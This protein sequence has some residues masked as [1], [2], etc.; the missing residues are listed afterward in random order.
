MAIGIDPS[1]RRSTELLPCKGSLHSSA[2][3]RVNRFFVP[4][5][6]ACDTSVYPVSI[7]ACR[8]TRR[9]P[10]AVASHALA[11]HASLL[12]CPLQ[13][14]TEKPKD[15]LPGQVVQIYEWGWEKLIEEM[16][17]KLYCQLPI[18][19]TAIS[20]EWEGRSF[21]MDV[22]KAA[23]NAYLAERRVELAE[24]SWCI[25]EDGVHIQIVGGKKPFKCTGPI[26]DPLSLAFQLPAALRLFHESGLVWAEALVLFK[27]MSEDDKTDVR[28]MLSHAIHCYPALFECDCAPVL[29]DTFERLLRDD[30]LDVAEGVHKHYMSF[31]QN[32]AQID[33]Y[34][35]RLLASMFLDQGLWERRLHFALFQSD[36]LIDYMECGTSVWGRGTPGACARRVLGRWAGVCVDVWG[37]GLW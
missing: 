13:E 27:C 15:L 26:V 20:P 16:H 29:C 18:V 21:W 25:S 24:G 37:G 17:I 30:D 5:L 31:V 4:F 2:R 6:F 23:Y 22:M 36:Q 7:A 8:T 32:L 10:P 28:W 14:C 11:L 1:Q 19:L 3:S 33:D 35:G 9:P 12:P 34:H